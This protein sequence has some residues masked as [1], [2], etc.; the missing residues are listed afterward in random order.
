MSDAEVR[1]KV[2]DNSVLTGGDPGG[3]RVAAVTANFRCLASISLSLADRK[4]VVGAVPCPVVLE[5]NM[6]SYSILCFVLTCSIPKCENVKLTAL[7]M[8]AL[9]VQVQ[10]L[11]RVVG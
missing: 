9:I 10:F 4:V 3:H 2:E 7:P 8:G 11:S 5:R 6:I 1:L